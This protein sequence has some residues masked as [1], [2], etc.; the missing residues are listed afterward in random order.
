M[1][2][3]FGQMLRRLRIGAGLS[4]NAL[5][6][7][8]GCDPAYV[9]RLERAG[10]IQRNGDLIRETIPRR[11]IVCAFGR[12]LDLGPSQTDRLLVAAGLAPATDWQTRA[13]RAE[14]ALA[15]IRRAFDDA[16]ADG[17]VF[18]RRRAV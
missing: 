9:N 2:E 12:I 15:A 1:S 4:Q 13:I 16:D 3:T 7:Q 17:P 14:A 5:A 10:L 18:I 11:T 8:A 6:H